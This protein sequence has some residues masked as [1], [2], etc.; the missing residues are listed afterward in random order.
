VF[1][2]FGWTEIKTIG[3]ITNCIAIFVSST[4]TPGLQLVRDQVDE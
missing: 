1:A 2:V 3:L 4:E